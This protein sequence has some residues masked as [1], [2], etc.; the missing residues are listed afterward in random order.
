ML[1]PYHTRI[2]P[3]RL[4]KAWLQ[5]RPARTHIHTHVCTHIRAAIQHQARLG[6]AGGPGSLGDD[7]GV[8]NQSHNDWV[9]IVVTGVRGAWNFGKGF[10]L[11]FD[12]KWW[13]IILCPTP[14]LK[15]MAERA[16]ETDISLTTTSPPPKRQK[17]WTEM[18]TST[19][20]YP[21]IVLF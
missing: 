20:K 1:T 5:R 15:N 19:S 11:K 16:Q 14:K 6:V 18:A 21:H 2:S 10:T 13:W 8:T 4:S 9:S 12:R 7:H 3:I 17:T